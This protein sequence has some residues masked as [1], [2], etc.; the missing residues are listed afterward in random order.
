MEVWMSD[1]LALESYVYSKGNYA[2]LVYI[3]IQPQG[4]G[5]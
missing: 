2:R 3:K 5:V 4:Y 1:P